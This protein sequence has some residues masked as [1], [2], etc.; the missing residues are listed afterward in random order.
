MTAKEKLKWLIDDAG[1]D[2]ATAK[3]LLENEKLQ[4]K[5]GSFVQQDEYDS[6]QAKA[7]ELELSYNGTKDKPGA[8]AYQKWYAENFDKVKSYEV[9][10]AKY[11]ERFGAL[12]VASADDKG[13]GKGASVGLS[14]EDLEKKV[15][16]LIQT[17]Y[18]TRWSDLVTNSG[19]IVQKHIRAGRKTDIDFAKLSE[20]AQTKNGN[21]MDAY[22]EYDKPEREAAAK[23]ATDAEVERR[24]NEKL[25]AARTQQFFPAGADAT[26]SG[27]GISPLSKAKADAPKYDRSKVIESAVTGKYENTVQ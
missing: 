16:N 19:T 6:L 21:L 26:P 4:K 25:A 9:A 7:A 18:A 3:A 20:I 22:D 10:L 23:A 8:A 15:D 2:E 11:Q 1:L 12:D 13:K 14:D 17:K 5:A 24:V 27:S